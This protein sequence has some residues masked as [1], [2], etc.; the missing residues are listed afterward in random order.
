[1]TILTSLLG[2]KTLGLVLLLLQEASPA[3]SPSSN[4]NQFTITEMVKNMGGVAIGVDPF[5]KE[6]EGAVWV[7]TVAC[8]EPA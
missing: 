6:R 1:M 5:L 7:P 4:V 3:A 8:G 2:T